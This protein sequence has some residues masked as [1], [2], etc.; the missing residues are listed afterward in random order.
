MKHFLL[1]SAGVIA[2]SAL[3]GC[4][5]DKYDLSDIDTTVKV[6]VNDL[7]VPVNIDP[8][9]MKT[10]FDIN[11][12]D[13]DATVKELDGV[14][15]IVRSGSFS[16]NEIKFQPIHLSSSVS[17]S[18][19]T[20]ISTGY[21]G[22]VPGGIDIALP[23]TTEDVSVSYSSSD[24]P[25]EVADIT[26]LGANFS[27]NYTLSFNELIGH[28]TRL[29]VQNVE[30]DF[31]K[32]LTGTMN[33][34]TYDAEAGKVRIPH[35]DLTSPVLR[36]SLT[37]TALDFD[38][39]GG[40]FNAA[41][42]TADI[43]ANIQIVSGELCFNSSD[44]D[45]HMPSTINLHAEGGL[46]DI[47]VTTFS[48]RV[49]YNIDGVNI[50]PVNLDDLPDV[51][52]QKDTRITL[53]N[54]QI[55]LHIENPLS[56]YKLTAQTG[57]TINS[58]FT[59]DNGNV[60]STTTHA[61]AAPGYFEINDAAQSNYC[62]SPLGATNVPEGFSPATPVSFK[63]LTT[64]LDGAGLPASLDITLDDPKVD[65]KPVEN[66]PIGSNLGIVDGKY[67]FIAP[68]SFGEGSQIVYTDTET[69]WGSDDL[70]AITIETLAVTTKISSQL[71]FSVNFTG[72]PIDADGN[73]INNVSIEGAEVPA[74]C[75]DH[76]ITIR[77][78]G[79]IRRLDGIEFTAKGFVPGTMNSPVTPDMSIT[80][81]DI[82]AT[83]SG[84]Y[85]K[86]L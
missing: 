83:V 66:L 20:Q 85:E 78:T 29:S 21:S 68:L 51:L 53:T 16:S 10:I 4:V 32:G 65:N 56:P 80:C 9:T 24:I 33:I 18:S 50:N 86:E 37:C 14:Y 13:P 8:I 62:L 6:E 19:T 55:Y 28:L 35:A 38:K 11:E 73:R 1:L 45:G 72:Y 49:N 54:P 63:S 25:Y 58:V 40:T 76:E 41:T 43:Q 12:D 71:P 77:I 70:D 22:E 5:D 81:K 61:L 57:I 60:T 3:T 52:R 59:D 48:G 44:F 64:V 75:S 79:E 42:H 84:Y 74:N 46:T 69:G 31:P 47:D 30:V 34:G 82:H 36:L 26:R 23:F 7:T 15:A 17:A 67:E 39:I 27:I 2:A